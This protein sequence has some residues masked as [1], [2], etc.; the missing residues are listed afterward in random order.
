MK[1]KTKARI[2]VLI[3]SLAIAVLSFFA[4][5]QIRSVS[6]NRETQK[7]PE[8]ARAE[9]LQKQLTAE[10]EN[11]AK[12]QQEVE[13]QRKTIAQ[14]RAQDP[15]EQS[16]A[17]QGQLDKAE[18]MAGLATVEGEGVT[19]LLDDAKGQALTGDP[20]NY[21]IHDSDIL[22]V[23]NELRD[24]GAE[25][26]SINGERILATTEIRCAGSVL[27]ANNQR[28][29]APFTIQAIGDPQKL[30]AALNLRNGVADNLRQWGIQV[31]VT[32]RDKII[33]E[34]YKGGMQ[35]EYAQRTE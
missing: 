22:Q 15:D 8:L 18:M 27:S 26:L 7:T 4:T 17:L 32:Q 6:A 34:G 12:L 3:L 1:P 5:W 13:E 35:F 25:A 14:L 30:S 9:E 21:I 24:A 31:E 2:T 19:V 16:Q 11:S 29:A 28:I 33:I 23:L 10:L 20:N